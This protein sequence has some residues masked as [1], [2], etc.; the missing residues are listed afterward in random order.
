MGEVGIA[1]SDATSRQKRAELLKN[2]IQVFFQ[3]NGAG[4][5]YWQWNKVRDSQQ[6]DVLLNTNDPLLP[7]FKE[8]ADRFSI[9]PTVS[10]YIPNPTSVPTSIPTAVPTRIVPTS[11]PTSTSGQTLLLDDSLMGRELNQFTF[12]GSHWRLCTTCGNGLYN[13]TSHVN[14]TAGE[15]VLVT[16]TGKQISLYGATD[17]DHGIGQVSI[18]GKYLQNINFYSTT[19]KENTLLWTSPT[20]PQGTYTFMLRVNGTKTTHSN[21]TIVEIDNVIITR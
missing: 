9:T 14:A 19:R 16:F 18:N 17:N 15:Y 3:H 8:Y 20:L 13:G 21:E 2:K 1:A 7:L 12:I 11:S 6:Y 4:Y 5:M 10:A